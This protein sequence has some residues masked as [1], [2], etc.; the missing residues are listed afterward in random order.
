MATIDQRIKLAR[1]RM[2]LSKSALS[3][4]LGVT[5]TSCISW[6]LPEADRNSARPNVENLTHLAVVCSVRFDWLANG[7]GAM[8][9]DGEKTAAAGDPVIRKK[10]L[11]PDQRLLLDLFKHLPP[12]KQDAVMELLNDLRAKRKADS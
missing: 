2:D 8:T 6:E 11:P 7:T 3:R 12:G 9:Y 4:I 10:Q 5:P 1:Q